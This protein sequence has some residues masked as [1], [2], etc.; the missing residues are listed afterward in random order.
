MCVLN[1][2]PALSVDFWHTRRGLEKSWQQSTDVSSNSSA[3]SIHTAP[4]AFVF[5]FVFAK[6][7]Y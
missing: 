3:L 6:V 7:T 5:S 4:A 1:Q 2:V